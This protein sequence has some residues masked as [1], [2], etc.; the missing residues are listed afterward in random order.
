METNVKILIVV[1]VVALVLSGIF[2][3]G[4]R[5]SA[6]YDNFIPKTDVPEDI[7]EIIPIE[8]RVSYLYSLREMAE[9]VEDRAD[10]EK[11]VS[12]SAT[13]VEKILET[14]TILNVKRQGK[15]IVQGDFDSHEDVDPMSNKIE[16]S[17]PGSW[18]ILVELRYDAKK[19]KVDGKYSS[20]YTRAGR[21]T[22]DLK[23]LRCVDNTRKLFNDGGNF[24]KYLNSEEIDAVTNIV[25]NSSG[26]AFFVENIV[27]SV[28]NPFWGTYNCQ[29]KLGEE[30]SDKVFGN[31]FV[32]KEASIYRFLDKNRENYVNYWKDGGEFSNNEVLSERYSCNGVDNKFY[33][34][35]EEKDVFPI[36]FYSSSSS[37]SYSLERGDEVFYIKDNEVWKII[38]PDLI[39]NE[40]KIEYSLRSGGETA[41]SGEYYKDI[42]NYCYSSLIEGEKCK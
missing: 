30:Y 16:L 18:T 29:I 33:P 35:I 25:C 10:L 8:E 37:I 9:Q 3:F 38:Y 26:L 5:F 27:N 6:V 31:T 24:F 19:R 13:E 17:F 15:I 23:D 1:I 20:F 34:C 40:N 39:K 42:T 11:K 36:R 14:N 28:R 4:D 7:D 41:L 12:L 2:L 22:L 21:L 32:E